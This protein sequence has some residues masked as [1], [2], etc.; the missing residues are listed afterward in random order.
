MDLD[1]SEAAS[2]LSRGF[3]KQRP[4]VA[5]LKVTGRLGGRVSDSEGCSDEAV[6]H[7]MFLGAQQ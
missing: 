5:S 4:A 1:A 7:V 3:F 6:P 2:S